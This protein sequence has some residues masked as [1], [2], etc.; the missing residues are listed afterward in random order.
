MVSA[1]ALIINF[2][3]ANKEA[4]NCKREN[5]LLT[6]VN[7]IACQGSGCGSVGRAVASDSRGQQFESCHRQKFML[8]IYCQLY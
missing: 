6:F 4:Q 3:V 5:S 2:I 8:N 1:L 7:I